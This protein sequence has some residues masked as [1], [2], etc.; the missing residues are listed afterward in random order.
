MVMLRDEHGGIRARESHMKTVNR[1]VCLIVLVAAAA[2]LAPSPSLAVGCADWVQTSVHTTGTYLPAEQAYAR[3]FAF[4]LTFDCNGSPVTLTVQRAMG[5]LPVCEARQSV[6]V[7]GTLSVSS[8]LM[9]SVYQIIDPTSVKCLTTASSGPS[10]AERPP[11]TPPVQVT[12]PARAETPRAETPSP[13]AKA[14]G[15]SA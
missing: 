13:P 8:K 14:L 15:P 6:E 2:I 4:G 5:G 12:P 10:A 1:F 7:V 9:G 11:V 3:P